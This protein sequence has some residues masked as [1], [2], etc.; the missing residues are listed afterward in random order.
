MI[1]PTAEHVF[2]SLWFLS[3]QFFFNRDFSW[4]R[5]TC[6]IWHWSTNGT[7]CYSQP[8]KIFVVSLH[9]Q[10]QLQ[11]AAVASDENFIWPKKRKIDNRGTSF[12]LNTVHF[13]RCVPQS[14]TLRTP[15]LRVG[16]LGSLHWAE[17]A[18]RQICPCWAS[19]W[20][21]TPSLNINVFA[22]CQFNLIL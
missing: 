15:L 21:S 8:L 19:V 13:G 17:A 9:V 2:S 11:T 22:Q 6:L 12:T 1:E 14:L 18:H 20:F 5:A 16:S 7:R 4:K 3:G 10:S